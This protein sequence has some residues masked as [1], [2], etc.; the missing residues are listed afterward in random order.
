MIEAYN[1]PRNV[2][3]LA[4]VLMQ[5]LAGVRAADKVEPRVPARSA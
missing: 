4:D 3:R 5:E 1:L 2:R